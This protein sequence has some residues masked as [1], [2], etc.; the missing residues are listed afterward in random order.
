MRVQCAGY[1]P[2]HLCAQQDSEGRTFR[3]FYE[4]PCCWND[5][6]VYATLP[7]DAAFHWIWRQLARQL[8][9][10][11]HVTVSTHTRDACSHDA[12]AACELRFAEMQGSPYKGSLRS[13][14]L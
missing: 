9:A 6:L 13:T 14:H 5:R 10:A 11:P 12:T 2:L 3:R 8:L 4:A 1:L 7:N